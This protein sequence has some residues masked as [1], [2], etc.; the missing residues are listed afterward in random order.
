M[1]DTLCYWHD[2]KTLIIDTIDLDELHFL[3][4]RTTLAIRRNGGSI[5]VSSIVEVLSSTSLPPTVN[6]S[7][8]PSNMIFTTNSVSEEFPTD[9]FPLPDFFDIFKGGRDL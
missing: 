1:N 9:P 3:G 8:G 4:D 7:G 6:P 5:A 2:D